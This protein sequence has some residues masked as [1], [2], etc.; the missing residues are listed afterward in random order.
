MPI[1]RVWTAQVRTVTQ[2]T[3][4]TQGSEKVHTEEKLVRL[5]KQMYRGGLPK[6]QFQFFLES[7]FTGKG[8]LKLRPYPGL[9][10]LMIPKVQF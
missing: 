3:E 7:N 2:L 5:Q 4:G 8:F 10:S 1:R 9:R 6:V